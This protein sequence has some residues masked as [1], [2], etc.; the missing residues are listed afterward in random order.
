MV[1]F[2]HYDFRLGCDTPPPPLHLR[3]RGERDANQLESCFPNNNNNNNYNNHNNHNNHNDH[4]MT[5]RPSAA[6]KKSIRR[7]FY[8]ASL[9]ECKKTHGLI[10]Q[11]GR[12]LCC[13]RACRWGHSR[14]GPHRRQNHHP[15][16]TGWDQQ[17]DKGIKLAFAQYFPII[18]V[19][20][21]NSSGQP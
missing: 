19:L 5:S 21:E 11:I 4:S 8:Q 20:L 13:F 10:W 17:G 3:R 1:K 18:K 14:G 15:R 7:S 16:N 12:A 9:C 2:P 6:G